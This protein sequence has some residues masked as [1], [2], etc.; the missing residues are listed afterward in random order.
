MSWQ[1]SDSWNEKKNHLG[2]NKKMNKLDNPKRVIKYKKIIRVGH[3]SSFFFFQIFCVEYIYVGPENKSMA[4]S[5]R[6]KAKINKNSIR[7]CLDE[8]FHRH[9]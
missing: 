1:V 3:A 4:P 6:N 5:I 8:L 9:F 7:P 2:T